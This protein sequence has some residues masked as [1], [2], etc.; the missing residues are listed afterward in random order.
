MSD[1]FTFYFNV[2][3]ISIITC[4]IAVNK[5]LISLGCTSPIL[6]ILKQSAFNTLPGYITKPI[7]IREQNSVHVFI[8]FQEVCYKKEKPHY[9]DQNIKFI[10]NVIKQMSWYII[11]F[12]YE[13]YSRNVSCALNLIST[14]LLHK[15]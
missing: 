1:I 11:N 8:H 15:I 3:F 12:I 9:G 2:I 4:F 13:G 7:K 5:D 6:P 10:Y 14:F